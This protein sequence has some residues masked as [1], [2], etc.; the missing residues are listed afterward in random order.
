MS[1]RHVAVAGPAHEAVQSAKSVVEIGGNAVDAAV[2]AICT[3]CV[4]EVG[5]VSPMGGAY[6]NIWAPGQEPLVLDGNVEMP[7]R[8]RP[9]EWFGAGVRDFWLDYYGGL[10]VYGG[11]GSVAVPGMFAALD[12]ASKRWGRLPWRELLQPAADIARQ[13]WPL[14]PAC[15]YYLRASADSLFAWDPQ[16][17]EFMTQNGSQGSPKLGEMLRSPDL[18]KSLEAIARDGA[19]TLYTGE[20]AHVIAADMDANEGLLSLADLAAYRTA[21]RPAVRARLGAWDIGVNPPPSIGGP[22]LSAMLRLLAHRRETNGHSDIIDIIDIQHAVLNY[23]RAAIDAAEDLE[24]AG[25]ELLEAVQEL[26]PDGLAAIISSPETIHVS[27]VDE[28]GLAC[29][30]TTSAGYG[31]GL[32]TPGT[33][34]MMNN[35][36]G[37]PELNRRGLHALPPGTRLA[38]NMTP[39]TARRDDGSMLAIGSPGADRITTALFQVLAGICLD[40]QS[41]QAAIEQ[42]R[43]HVAFDDEGSPRVEFE[44]LASIS[45]GVA[46]AG[47]TLGLPTVGHE[48][49]GMYFGGVGAAMMSADGAVQAAGDPRR[50]A[51]TGA[52]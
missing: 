51:A 5:I 17:H 27:T 41:L 50:T 36:M 15:E 14:G 33:G 43:A 18:A 52:W 22:V 49:V 19:Q 34:L 16:T 6:I 26:G 8:G 4:T 7:G 39:S 45:D 32:T 31:S 20:L 13:G 3:A 24:T 47:A 10:R 38:S 46:R 28:D 30:I 44:D 35:A 23:R 48:K 25:R 1:R 9:K 12:E 37:E 29:S 2:A 21:A 40:D 11:H 42:A